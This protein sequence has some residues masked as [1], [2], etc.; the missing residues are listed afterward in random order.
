MT[1]SAQANRE[2]QRDRMVRVMSR[3]AW[4]M[5]GIAIGVMASFV[6][7]HGGGVPW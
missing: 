7:T 1:E 6:A 4:I 5:L 2:A 3:F